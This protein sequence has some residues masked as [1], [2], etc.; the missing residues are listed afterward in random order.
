MAKKQLHEISEENLLSELASLK[1]NLNKMKLEKAVRG[2]ADTSQFSK[3]RENIAQILTELRKR[4]LAEYTPEEL[5]D[6]SRI[7]ARRA[8]LKKA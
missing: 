1:N 6:R 8:R 5:E 2:I 7:R 4:D 3:M